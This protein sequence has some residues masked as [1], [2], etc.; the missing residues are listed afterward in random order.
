MIAA[1]TQ[2]LIYYLEYRTRMVEGAYVSDLLPFT[3]YLDVIM[4]KTHMR[5]GRGDGIDTGEVGTFG[6]WLAVFQFIGFMVGGACVY[7]LLKAQPT[8]EPCNRYLNTLVTKKDSFA[9]ID[10]LAA[11]YDHEFEHPVDSPEFAQHVGRE[12]SAGKA[13]RGTLNMTTR[14]MGCPTCGGQYVSEAV[15][16]FNGREWK[17]VNELKRIVQ[18]PQGLNV[19]HIYNA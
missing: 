1:L 18:M 15:Q 13:E 4:T 14:I 5:M 9:D 3:D 17:D 12:F 7:F 19:A 11:Y 8:C 16:V 10:D 2:A 6:Y